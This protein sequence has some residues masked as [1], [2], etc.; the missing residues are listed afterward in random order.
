MSSL[1]LERSLPMQ[2][3]QVTRS[4]TVENLALEAP[5]R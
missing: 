1:P 5:I 3:G 4:M 2:L